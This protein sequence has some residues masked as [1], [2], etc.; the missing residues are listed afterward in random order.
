MADSLL[1]VLRTS[2]GEEWQAPL[3]SLGVESLDDIRYVSEQD[4]KGIGMNIVQI[5]K[6]DA[7]YQ[8]ECMMWTPWGG[9]FYP[10]HMQVGPMPMGL[11]PMMAVPDEA[12]A[13]G[14]PAGSQLPS[15][16]ELQVLHY[17]QKNVEQK[18]IDCLDIAVSML[19]VVAC[20]VQENRDIIKS[21]MAAKDK[22]SDSSCTTDL[23]IQAM[24]AT[25]RA[26]GMCRKGN[27]RR[28]LDQAEINIRDAIVL[29]TQMGIPLNQREKFIKTLEDAYGVDKLPRNDL[30]KLMHA[31]SKAVCPLFAHAFVSNSRKENATRPAGL[32]GKRS[33][34]AKRQAAAAE[35]EG[36]EDEPAWCLGPLS[37]GSRG[38][39]L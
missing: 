27:P 25:V 13:T 30:A 15:P 37:G 7:A 34:D 18:A 6:L 23:A 26:K 8:A 5:R 1:G 4:L 32:K 24:N 17:A 33:R 16:S 14:G 2:V 21:V 31:H 22:L 29:R 3:A 11:P 12:M 38:S 9:T 19:E 10:E 28:E 39:I 35:A 20:T 36:S